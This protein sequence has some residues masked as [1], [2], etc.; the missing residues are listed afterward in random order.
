MYNF[1]LSILN[2][3]CLFVKICFK[4]NYFLSSN[5]DKNRI[6]DTM[7]IVMYFKLAMKNTMKNADNNPTPSPVDNLLSA[8]ILIIEYIMSPEYDLDLDQVKLIDATILILE[9]ITQFYDKNKEQPSE[10]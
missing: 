7:S 6:C 10:E 4:N 1:N 2:R 8:N 9:Y 3:I 5:I